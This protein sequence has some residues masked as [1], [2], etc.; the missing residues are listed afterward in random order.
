M[1]KKKAP[2]KHNEMTGMMRWLL[3]YADLVTLLLIVF[4]VLFS[5]SKQDAEK[6]KDL[7]QY[8]RAAFGGVLQQGPT[9]LAGQGER[10][11]PDLFQRISAAVGEA[12]S[13]GAGSA[14]AK[15][16]K[17]ERGIVVSLLTDRVLFD[18]GSVALKPEMKQILDAL[19]GP[20]RDTD[21]SVLVEGHTDDR[22]VR[23]GRRYVDNMELST[24]RAC[25]VV[26]YLIESGEINPRR[27]SAAGYAEYRPVVPNRDEAA[28][29]R[30]RRI[31]I[32]ILKGNEGT[33]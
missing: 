31:D 24:L 27:M 21:R 16:F 2:E 22:P 15:V 18:S 14:G 5:M 10:I 29:R 20:L 19:G 1:A 8:L 11:I 6:F 26:R 30:N 25:N 32:V 4:I 28:R 9:F 13:G 7:A 33:Q 23:G 12:G 3:T 17:N